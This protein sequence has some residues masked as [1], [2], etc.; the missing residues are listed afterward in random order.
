MDM[1][2]GPAKR[3]TAATRVRKSRG[4][5]ESAMIDA[6]T[7]IPGSKVRGRYRTGQGQCPQLGNL[8]TE[9]PYGLALSYLA[10]ESV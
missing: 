2:S 5:E 1:S 8:T 3:L 4:E 10:S 6:G 9:G 7:R